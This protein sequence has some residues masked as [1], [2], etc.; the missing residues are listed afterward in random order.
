MK[1]PEATLRLRE[2]AEMSQ[3]DFAQL[4]GIGFSAV[5]K[6]EAGRFHEPDPRIMMFAR[7]DFLLLD[8]QFARLDCLLCQFALPGCKLPL[9]NCLL[10]LLECMLPDCWLGES[11]L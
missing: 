9:F 2:N 7:S 10:A 1:L 6:Y 8:G 4:L 5:Q 11:Q 3:R